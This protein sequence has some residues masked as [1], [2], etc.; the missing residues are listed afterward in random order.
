MSDCLSTVA[1][2]DPAASILR[3]N[4]GADTGFGA[5]LLLVAGLT[6]RSYVALAHVDSACV[7]RNCSS[8]NRHDLSNC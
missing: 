1:Y 3:L 8:I 7:V 2:R 4:T 5:H 6:A